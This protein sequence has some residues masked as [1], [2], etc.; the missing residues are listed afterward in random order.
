MR[1]IFLHAIRGVSGRARQLLLLLCAPAGLAAQS[2]R[3]PLTLA[4]LVDRLERSNPMLAAARS[5]ADAAYARIGPASALPDPRAE[6]AVMN[7]ML[8]ELSTMS[9]L[10]MDQLTVTQ[11]LPIASRRAMTRAAEARARAVATGVATQRFAARRDAAEMLA[12]WWQADAARTVMNE[13]R[14]LLREGAAAASAMYG[15]GQAQ[16]SEVLRMQAELTRMTAEWTAMDAMRHSAAARLS[17]MLDAPLHADSVQPEL[18]AAIDAPTRD[19]TSAQSPDLL[20][21]HHGVEAAAAAEALARRERWPELEVGLSLG[22]RPNST[23]R[24]VSV[25]AGAS[26]PVFAKQRQQQMIQEM[27]AMRRMAEAEARGAAAEN[28]AGVIEATAALERAR[29]LQRLYD[30]TLL[31]QLTA[32]RE[33]ADAAYRAG[34]G[35]IE[36]VIDALMTL[37]TARIARLTARADEVRVLARLESLTGRAWLAVPLATENRP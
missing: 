4:Q 3:T 6:F 17:A 37:N 11:M 28:R 2:P 32:V 23:E 9:P 16:Q 34:T 8:P 19:T 35:S 22:Q 7:R 14:A 10:A 21:A 1:P 13:T 5:A 27:V 15:A 25:M 12:D 20:A 31:P 18:P 24:M 26:I 30:G 33:S 36:A 29:A